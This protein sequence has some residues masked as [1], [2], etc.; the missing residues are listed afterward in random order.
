M[1]LGIS[2]AYVSNEIIP[3]PVPKPSNALTIGNPAAT[4]E[5]NV[6]NSTTKLIFLKYNSNY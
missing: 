3:T 6:I 5:P 4:T 1:T 2:N